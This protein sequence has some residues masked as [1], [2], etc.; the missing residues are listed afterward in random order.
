V[1]IP[2]WWGHCPEHGWVVT[3]RDLRFADL[4][5]T[6]FFRCMDA[7]VM[8]ADG[9]QLRL[10][11]HAPAYYET[12][13]E[14]RRT[15]LKQGFQGLR[16]DWLE[17]RKVLEVVIEHEWAEAVRRKQLEDMFTAR[18]RLFESMRLLPP[19]S[20]SATKYRTPTHC[21]SCKQHLSMSTNLECT[22]CGWMICFC[23]AC[24]CG[25]TF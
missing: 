11:I 10:V 9:D 24:K 16:A 21:Y 8:Y 13:P 22:K 15:E 14:P 12:L 2:E 3:H 4:E 7:S 6:P 5:K 17:K 1:D 25:T 19:P 20:R 18:K 23:G